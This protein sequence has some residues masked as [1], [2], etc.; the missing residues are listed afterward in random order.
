[1]QLPNIQISEREMVISTQQRAGVYGLVLIQTPR[2]TS[3]PQLI[4]SQA[5]ALSKYTWD[6][7]T[8][9]MATNQS[10]FNSMMCYL[11]ESNVLWVKRVVPA[12]A[13]YSAVHLMKQG[14]TAPVEIDW[15][16]TTIPDGYTVTGPDV[17]GL[18]TGDPIY[19]QGIYL[20]TG[21][22]MDELY[23]IRLISTTEF[24]LCA[25]YEDALL[26]APLGA[27]EMTNV[28]TSGSVYMYV[29]SGAV[30]EGIDIPS[31]FPI[32]PSDACVVYADSKGSGGDGVYI[33]V[34]VPRQTEASISLAPI[35]DT[36]TGAVTVS[37]NAG[38]PATK[39]WPALVAVASDYKGVPVRILPE[40]GSS[41]LPTGWSSS[42][43]YRAF[44]NSVYPT[45]LQFAY[46]LTDEAAYLNA[47]AGIPVVPTAGTGVGNIRIAPIGTVLA[48][49]GS[50]GI[51][52]PIT[53][54]LTTAS[55]PVTGRARVVF[56]TDSP[57]VS[58]PSPLVAGQVYWTFTDGLADFEFKV[59]LSLNDAIH[60]S[61]VPMIL[62][63]VDASFKA[64]VYA[65]EESIA[66]TTL[67]ETV[68]LPGAWDVDDESLVVARDYYGAASVL[69]DSVRIHVPAPGTYPAYDD[70][71]GST[72]LTGTTKLIVND[73]TAG[74][75][76][77]ALESDPTVVLNFG[78]TGTKGTGTLRIYH[79]NLIE[80]D[81]NLV[82]GTPVRF[83]GDGSNYMEG[84]TNNT[85]AYAVPDPQLAMG[86]VSG[87]KFRIKFAVTIA[88]ACAD[89]PVLMAAPTV[90]NPGPGLGTVS[91]VP[92][93]AAADNDGSWNDTRNYDED[94]R[95]VILDGAVDYAN[96][97]IRM[98]LFSGFPQGW[99]AGEPV[100]LSLGLSST[101]PAPLNTVASYYVLPVGVDGD[102]NNWVKLATRSGRS[103]TSVSDLTPVVLSSSQLGVGTMS[104]IPTQVSVDPNTFRIKVWTLETRQSGAMNQ[105]TV[106]VAN[107]AEEFV[108]SLYSDQM[109]GSG[110]NIYIVNRLKSSNYIRGLAEE[111]HVLADVPVVQA[112]PFLTALG[113]GAD[114]GLD[115]K[116]S[117]TDADL[118]AAL[119]DFT[120]PDEKQVRYVLDGG[121]TMNGGYQNAILDFCEARNDCVGILN[122]PQALEDETE[123]Y[124]AIVDWRNE[125]LPS[126]KF[127]SVFTPWQ[128]Y[129][130]V[131]T[132]RE[133]AV[134]AD[135]MV[136]AQMSKIDRTLGA[137]YAAA[138]TTYGVIKSL[139]PW[140]TTYSQ[141]QLDELYTN[142]INP[143]IR[144]RGAGSIIWGN[145]TLYAIQAPSRSINVR[146]KL[147]EIEN[148]LRVTL[149]NFIYW[150]IDQ[151]TRNAMKSVVDQYLAG[152]RGTRGITD[153]YVVCNGSNNTALDEDNLTNNIWIF[154]RPLRAAEYVNVIVGVTS[155]GVSFQSAVESITGA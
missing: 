75:V 42:V 149:R 4:A 135:G 66:V 24:Q 39:F 74:K 21:L 107:K 78:G 71:V 128:K 148:D 115:G 111:I 122:H 89:P 10:A 114:G 112:V 77:L 87:N 65:A 47:V 51:L 5:E 81:Q 28:P 40:S 119:A 48:F 62:Q 43:V 60:Q 104:I 79:S 57:T 129:Y 153:F 125:V 155:A 23:Y 36:V 73:F 44:G 145:R 93:F 67:G 25:T 15:S 26:T 134:P 64:Y 72:A 117:V 52:D 121:L 31:E 103:F 151:T 49:T 16:A 144:M 106:T 90:S 17:D 18:T 29:A 22:V 137:Q 141:A 34:E 54:V 27:V 109:D 35:L 142:G 150:P 9:Q 91:L 136:A 97:M 138:G 32:P 86:G 6:G 59:A 96:S 133:I 33:T 58:L 113:G 82:S 130:D 143:I 105:S 154:V 92:W 20:P 69:G 127:G 98:K 53:H 88:D 118:A 131:S 108:V 95:T 123:P 100:R 46:G 37:M 68:T 126:H 110:R 3:D 140:K 30:R 102:G 120:N 84:V 99:V 85:Q 70:G 94:E 61:A 55:V 147:C 139:G 19:V 83:E 56:F 41:V 116:G 124:R 101:L 2:G 152:V 132:G 63:T 50:A 76:K 45:R 8:P 13:L 146:R 1:M 80:I 14:S 12:D 7:R 11:R 38:D